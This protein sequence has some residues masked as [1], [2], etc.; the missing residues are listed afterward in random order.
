[1][2]LSSHYLR[3][4]PSQ[5]A[6]SALI[7]SLNINSSNVSIRM[8]APS[9]LSNLAEK[10]FYF[11]SSSSHIYQN[12]EEESKDNGPLDRWNSHVR[13]VTKLSARQDI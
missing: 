9:V 5:V 6:A 8:G 3:F 13:N 1:M 4:K 11:D 2:L 12:A 10:A 7:L